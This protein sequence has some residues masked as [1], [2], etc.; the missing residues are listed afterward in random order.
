MFYTAAWCTSDES[1]FRRELPLQLLGESLKKYRSRLPLHIVLL[2]GIERLSAGYLRSLEET[3]FILV[4][5]SAAFRE[6][7]AT[8]PNID[9]QHSRY[10]RNCLLR[11]VAF[12]KLF[13]GHPDKPPQFWHLDSDVLLHTSLDELANDTA[14]K[15]FML[16]GCPVLL[17]VSDPRWFEIYEANLA[18]MEK[19][20]HGYSAAAAAEKQ[21]C[22]TN[23]Y[24]LANNSFYRDPIGSDQ[25]LLEYLVSSKRLPQ[26][27]RSVIYRSRYF[28]VENPLAFNLAGFDRQGEEVVEFAMTADG[29]IQSGKKQV[30]FVHYQN[31][32]ARYAQVFLL[33]KQ[34][35]IPEWIIRLF[36]R[37]RIEEDRFITTF[38]FRVLSRLWFGC[39]PS[40]GR[41]RVIERL[42]DH[43]KGRTVADLLNF[44]TI[45][46]TFR[47]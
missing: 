3:G 23:D 19:D 1:A 43:T 25:D 33:L 17:T 42:N 31:G 22:R 14:G 10:E 35:H 21:R 12:R 39:H 13:K 6:I 16:Q 11:W 24:E 20:L 28:F 36:M 38:G 32:F 37:Y 27:D 18:A 41:S 30:P 34:W 26:N 46:S 4:D 5:Y 2:E 15:T 44:L 29:R 9:A 45:Y 8:Y 7:V 47:R 40:W